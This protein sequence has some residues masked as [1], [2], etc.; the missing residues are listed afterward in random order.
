MLICSLLF[1]SW[2][3]FPLQPIICNQEIY[4]KKAIFTAYTLSADETDGSPE[5]GAGNHN[6]KML[7]VQGKLCCA[8]RSLPLH[9]KINI[10]GIGDCE[11]LDRTSLKYQGR[12]DILFHT[13][14]EAFN[15]GKKELEYYIIK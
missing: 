1:S 7:C 13:K 15:F 3:C 10:K 11:I 12:I 6:L 9:T 14:K 8:S 5:I 4:D 2:L